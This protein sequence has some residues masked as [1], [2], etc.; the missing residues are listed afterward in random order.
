MVVANCTLSLHFSHCA[1]QRRKH[2]NLILIQCSL[3]SSNDFARRRSRCNRQPSPT[4]RQLCYG[5]QSIWCLP[6]SYFTLIFASA[7]SVR[8]LKAKAVDDVEDPILLLTSAGRTAPAN[9]ASAAP[10]ASL[11]SS[12]L[13]LA[14]HFD[15]IGELC[16]YRQ[17][18]GFSARIAF[19]RHSTLLRVVVT[20][21][22]FFRTHVA[23]SRNFPLN[24]RLRIL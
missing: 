22:G 7:V 18:M 14:R 13:K 24:R 20:S 10:F 9:G 11:V 17:T 2:K 8:D 5:C 16:F 3:I 23:A 19:H 4:A 15:L 21:L 1:E 6:S 12:H